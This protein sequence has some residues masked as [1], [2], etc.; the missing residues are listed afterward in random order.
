[1]GQRYGRMEDQKPRLVWHLTRVSLQGECL[2]QKLKA[3][4]SKVGDVLSRVEVVFLKR[5]TNKGLE[6]ELPTFG[7]Y[8]VCGRRS[9][10]LRD[11]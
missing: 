8:G 7:G 5:T 11:F 2:N 9:H 1:M 4:P 6:E 10:P 3:K